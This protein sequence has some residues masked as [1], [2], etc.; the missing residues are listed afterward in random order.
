MITTR[1]FAVVFSAAIL[2]FGWSAVAGP[3]IDGRVIDH[4][5]GTPIPNAFVIATW[6]AYGSDGFGSR[7]SCRHVEVVMTDDLGR[8]RIPTDGWGDDAFVEAYKAGWVQFFERK[9]VREEEEWRLR[10]LQQMI[11]FSGSPAERRQYLLRFD[12]LLMCGSA[13]LVTTLRPLYEALDQDAASLNVRTWFVH[14][15][16]NIEKARAESLRKESVK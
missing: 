15:L 3:T 2:A 1:I 9:S 13:D 11:P 14:L 16:Q 12:N 8:Y 10:I 4:N 6:M 5:G 7:T